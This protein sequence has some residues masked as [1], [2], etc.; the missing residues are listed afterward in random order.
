MERLRTL[1]TQVLEENAGVNGARS[2]L[3]M[4]EC[5]DLMYWR[6]SH[7]SYV[8]T[9]FLQWGWYWDVSLNPV[10]KYHL[11][12]DWIAQLSFP[13]PVCEGYY[14]VTRSWSSTAHMDA[15]IWPRLVLFLPQVFGI[16][17]LTDSNRGRAVR[18]PHWLQHNVQRDSYRIG[19]HR[20]NSHIPVFT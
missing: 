17:L 14:A 10:P 2:G 9:Y 4:T 7:R 19:F 20:G 1:C 16:S 12:G 18:M 6:S 15:G 8:M 11:H 13:S 5:S 3:V